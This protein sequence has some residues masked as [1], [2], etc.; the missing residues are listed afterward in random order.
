MRWQR[1]RM[2]GSR[3]SATAVTSSTIVRGG[4]SSIVFSIALADSFWLPAQPFGLEQDQHPPLGLDRRARRLGQDRVADVFFHA[5]R[6]AARRELHD[7]GM[8]PALHE[9]QAALVVADADQQRGEL[10]RRVLDPEP[11]GPTS[12]YAC[13]GRSLARR[14]VSTARS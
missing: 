4:G 7:V 9:P 14:S 2:V 5:V 1:D 8:D 3:S 6:R 11:R 13:D 10:T 12:R